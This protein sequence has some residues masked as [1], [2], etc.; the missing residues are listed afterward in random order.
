MA[1]GLVS[2]VLKGSE[3]LS[4]LPCARQSNN[5]ALQQLTSCIHDAVSDGSPYQEVW[6]LRVLHHTGEYC[7]SEWNS[8]S[9]SI[10]CVLLSK[11]LDRCLNALLHRNMRVAPEHHNF[12]WLKHRSSN[13][14]LV[15]EACQFES[16]AAKTVG[17]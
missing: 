10:V 15:G 12:N 3:A 1:L 6:L 4:P 14:L 7:Y 13:H 5:I 8:A 17:Q 9:A 2:C 16:N 11:F